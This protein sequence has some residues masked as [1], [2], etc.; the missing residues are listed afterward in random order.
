MSVLPAFATTCLC[1]AGK[2]VIGE[3]ELLQP[4]PF[5]GTNNERPP[6]E[7]T[8]EEQDVFARANELRQAREFARAERCYE[9]LFRRHAGDHQALWGF[10]LARY[11]VVFAID[12]LTKEKKATVSFPRS[13][14]LQQM[15][16][17]AKACALASPEKAEE[18]RQQAAYVDQ[19]QASI[20]QRTKKCRAYDVFLC[21][22][23][24]RPGQ[25]GVKTAEY[26]YML[27]LYE[28]LTAE[29]YNVFF[30]PKN[31]VPPGATYEA[32]I[33]HALLTSRVMLMACADE[34]HINSTWVRSEWL[35]FLDMMDADV[36]GSKTLVP[37]L[38]GGFSPEELPP[39]FVGRGGL[40]A[41]DMQSPWAVDRLLRVLEEYVPRTK[42]TPP[43][44]DSPFLT[45]EIPGGLRITG[46]TGVGGMVMIPA[47]IGGQRVLEI[48]DRAF[49][50]KPMN[51]VYIQ[52]AVQRIG[53]QAFSQCMQLRSVIFPPAL[54]EIGL[55]AF[56]MNMNLEWITLPVGLET[57]GD[58]A[59]DN[60]FALKTVTLPETLKR[61][62]EGAFENCRELNRLMV[63]RGVVSIGRLAFYGCETKL[64]VYG[65]TVAHRYAQDNLMQ[66]EVLYG[67]HSG[68]AP[69]RSPEP[70]EVH[71]DQEPG[72]VQHRP[73]AEVVHHE[74]ESEV[75]HHEPEPAEDADFP[76]LAEIREAARQL[77]ER[78]WGTFDLET[79][80]KTSP[81]SVPETPQQP[82]APPEPTPTPP[83]PEP[84][85]AK[86]DDAS[87]MQAIREAM[88]QL[89]QNGWGD[90]IPDEE[91]TAPKPETPAAS[92]E[93]E[94]VPTGGADLL[95]KAA[96]HL[97]DIVDGTSGA[98]REPQGGKAGDATQAA[99][100]EAAD[101]L[102]RIMQE[103]PGA[104]PEA[105]PEEQFRVRIKPDRSGCSIEKYTGPGGDVIIPPTIQGVP[106]VGI[107]D[108]A[109]R[110]VKGIRSIQLPRSI[111]YMS[112]KLFRDMPE[113]VIRVHKD[114][115]AHIHAMTNG[116]NFEVIG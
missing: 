24:E 66:A 113:V 18:Y 68:S 74:P 49:Q 86:E 96:A 50:G 105:N 80:G 29:G 2:F 73:E 67:S 37:L 41:Q 20:R 109:F 85:P 42:K 82:P 47:E 97:R 14:P 108:V 93:A 103:T 64:M 81:E 31:S 5:C 6:R 26:E 57:I 88:E 51:T 116:L 8:K 23:T 13:K 12:P 22:K 69:Q 15:P 45:E 102:A 34:K 75:T 30:A 1:C 16:E 25:K 63:P 62:G 112:T 91:P 106:V 36:D 59:F 110:S 17:F 72:G 46:Y 44:P 70:A 21:H 89:V 56:E 27:Q 61:I 98:P 38:Y 53:Q 43:V 107:W 99:L 77:M 11:G 101:R 3:G 65:G 92:P 33:Y 40:Q 100:A 71:H 58:Y 94:S 83:S 52:G 7:E 79:P 32:T 35:R 104:T 95:K 10:L 28:R 76:E 39:E 4:C 115:N 55:R 19:V 84:A 48:G 54:R 9:A 90:F 114:T 78:G 87:E 60:C 111:Q